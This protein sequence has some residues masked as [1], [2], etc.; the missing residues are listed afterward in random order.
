[1]VKTAPP[2]GVIMFNIILYTTSSEPNRINKSLNNQTIFEGSLREQSSIIN[3]TI[4]IQ[5]ENLSAF[6]YMYIAE[7]DRYYFITDITSVRNGL[8]RISAKVDVLMSFSDQIQ[9]VIVS[10]GDVQQYYDEEYLPSNIWR[11]T[12]K[13]KTDII[14]FPNGLNDSGDYILLT[15]GGVVS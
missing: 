1:M 11:S 9:N 3:P 2:W 12:A 6:N 15:S 8:W 13:T 5:A 10:I 7:F 4:T 14:S